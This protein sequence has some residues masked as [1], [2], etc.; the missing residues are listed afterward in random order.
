MGPFVSSFGNKYLLVVVDYVSKWVE[1]M[2]LS[3]NESKLV[4]F[5]LKKYIFT[6]FGMHAIISNRGTHFCS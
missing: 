2:P 5:F 3:N 1:A 6:R 4:T